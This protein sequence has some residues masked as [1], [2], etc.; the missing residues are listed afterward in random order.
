MNHLPAA[1]MLVPLEQ[2][3][4]ILKINKDIQNSS[5]TGGK[6]TVSIC[7]FGTGGKFT[8]TINNTGDHTFHWILTLS[9][10]AAANLPPVSTILM[11]NL[12]PC[13]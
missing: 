5:Y 9:V 3:C 4:F 13:Q 12:P 8:T 2:L 11:V 1:S 6:F 7:I 10:T